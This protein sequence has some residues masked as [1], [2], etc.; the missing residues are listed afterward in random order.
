M[1]V[2]TFNVGGIEIQAVDNHVLVNMMFR[3]PAW[4]EL[5]PARTSMLKNIMNAGVPSRRK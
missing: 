5:S 4:A 2:N 1:P 3:C